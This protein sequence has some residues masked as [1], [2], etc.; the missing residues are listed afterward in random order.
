MVWYSQSSVRIGSR[1]QLEFPCRAGTGYGLH[2]SDEHDELKARHARRIA[3]RKKSEGDSPDT[4]VEMAVIPFF[5]EGEGEET[6]EHSSLNTPTIAEM[7]AEDA[8]FDDAD[9]TVVIED[10]D[11]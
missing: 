3:A 2:M 1:D 6:G 8:D 11:D 10:E 7:H 4:L 9:D 5:I